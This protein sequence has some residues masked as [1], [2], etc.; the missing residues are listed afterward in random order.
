[1]KS[2]GVPLISTDIWGYNFFGP[3]T[4]EYATAVQYRQHS[5]RIRTRNS[6]QRWPRRQCTRRPRYIVIHKSCTFRCVVLLRC[7]VV[8]LSVASSVPSVIV[9][10][11]VA[12]HFLSCLL[13]RYSS[14]QLQTVQTTVVGTTCTTVCV[15]RLHER[16]HI[17]RKYVHS[18]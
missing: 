18:R 8:A 5:L 9:S 11:T 16:G 15:T 6:T 14:V 7:A 3:C 17:L 2:G 13:I 4:I 1:M 12:L 10:W